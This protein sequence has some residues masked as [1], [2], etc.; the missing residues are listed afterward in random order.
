MGGGNIVP[1]LLPA[2]QR[3]ASALH[4]RVE[5]RQLQGSPTAHVPP[6]RSGEQAAG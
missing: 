1:V 6:R 2:P 4:S 3:G 5:H